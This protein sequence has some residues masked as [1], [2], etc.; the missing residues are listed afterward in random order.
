MQFY[1]RYV[2]LGQ[3][4]RS[5][6]IP[7]WD[8]SQF[9]GAP[10]AAD[11]QS[12][13]MYLP[14]MVLFTALPLA[15]AA[16]AYVFLHLLLAGVFA[17]ALARVLR[18]GIGSSLIS[19]VAYEGS[20]ALYA[21]SVNLFTH[22][23]TIL[24]LPLAILGAEVAIGS[25]SWLA[26][27]WWWGLC[28]LAI[29][30]ALAI[31]IGQ[32]AYYVLLA[33][34]GYIGYRTLISPPKESPSVRARVLG[35]LLHGS[36]V[37]LFG[38]GLSA[39]GVLPRLE[40]NALSN[41]ANGYAGTE[42]AISGG[43]SVRAWGQLLGTNGFWYAGGAVVA[44]AVVAPVV[45]R[46]RYATP[47]FALLAL[48]TLILSMQRSTPLHLLLAV[49]PR[50][51]QLHQHFPQ[52]VLLVFYLAP[53]MLAGATWECIGA[54]G[55]KG[56]LIAVLPL[57]A[58][59]LLARVHLN[60]SEA[61]FVA[62]VSAS[63]L[64][65][66]RAALPGRGQ[67]LTVLTVA[68]VFVDLA[69]FGQGRVTKSTRVT[70]RWIGLR[71]VDL[72]RFYEPGDAGK[73]LQARAQSE[74]FRYFGF[75][76]R[77]DDR[78]NYPLQWAE[79]QANLLLTNNRA[80]V[81]RLHDVQGYNPVRIARYQHFFTALNARGQGYRRSDVYSTGL[82]SPL[83]DL[84]NVRYVVVPTSG[85]AQRTSVGGI[86]DQ[87]KLV[88]HGREVKVL[89]RPNV[90]PR[91]WL[92]HSAQR[93]EPHQALEQ[94][95]RGQVNPMETALL[96]V[97]PPMLAQPTDSTNEKIEI[98]AYESDRI[99]LRV[100]ADAPGLLM[101]SEVYYPAW[102]AYVNG[103]RSPVYVA[104]Y[105][106]RAVPVTAGKHVV[107]LRFESVALRDGIRVSLLFYA[108]LACLGMLL[109]LQKLWIREAEGTRL[110]KDRIERHVP[111]PNAVSASDDSI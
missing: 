27:G 2:Y 36:A 81:F 17:Y 54:W 75:N 85:P 25:H 65:A 60:V 64:L 58:A 24:W 20:S 93:V 62:S 82:D 108:L 38:L 96:E 55:R 35:L 63:A 9:A 67:L 15:L 48:S 26:R 49:L 19:A 28:G 103:G 87:Y 10:F 69:S 91:A 5:G 84:L 50:F 98:T 47:Y 16:K 11:P 95:A 74:P 61:V 92:I 30:Q 97:P 41:L 22:S 51:Q 46:V 94:L 89:E 37:L 77:L 43:W 40:Y 105:L 80:T 83:L 33:L 70:D 78:R 31:W 23:G 111:A 6:D 57:P 45:A 66:A 39:A 76:L 21:N 109:L 18:L 104:D 68:I 88:Y 106:L 13:W 90:L 42:E 56:V 14:A 53:A 29:S 107:E 4:L 86:L 79:P 99:E 8:P 1:P 100:E 73:F 71:K 3:S 110:A 101:L 59:L 52:H 32:G 72:A 44:L 102:K 34:G 12:G 7:G